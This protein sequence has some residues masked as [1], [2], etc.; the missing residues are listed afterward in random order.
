MCAIS[1]EDKALAAMRDRAKAIRNY[2][3]PDAESSDDS[4]DDIDYQKMEFEM[5][6]RETDAY[7]FKKAST[8]DSIDTLGTKPQTQKNEREDDTSVD[9]SITATPSPS[10]K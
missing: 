6:T 9:E 2:T 10:K 1:N 8:N 4:D 5:N 3:D 7:L